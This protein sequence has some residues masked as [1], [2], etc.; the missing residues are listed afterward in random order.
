MTIIK[1]VI[2]SKSLRDGRTDD[3]NYYIAKCNVCGREYYPKRN[4]SQFCSSNCNVYSWKEKKKLN[5]IDVIEPVI[6]IK[7]HTY[8]D[9]EFDR[10]IGLKVLPKFYKMSLND[11]L[12]I[13][14]F[15]GYGSGHSYEDNLKWLNGLKIGVFKELD[16]DIYVS[17]FEENLF[18]KDLFCIKIIKDIKID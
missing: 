1:R 14:N 2:G 12:K 9:W 11:T 17:K 5:V 15:H 18:D 8:N 6:Y 13:I 10:L 4:D 16:N 7:Y 3:G